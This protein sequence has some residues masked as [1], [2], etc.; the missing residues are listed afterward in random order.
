MAKIFC[1]KDFGTGDAIFFQTLEGVATYINA[2]NP[3]GGILEVRDHDTAGIYQIQ[4]SILE[5]L[6]QATQQYSGHMV[7]SFFVNFDFV[8][9]QIESQYILSTVNLLN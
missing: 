5:S 1:L 8:Y 9:T 6:L 7:L 4:P 2:K 3:I